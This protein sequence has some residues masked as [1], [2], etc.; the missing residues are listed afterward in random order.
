MYPCFKRSGMISSRNSA[1]EVF[2][3]LCIRVMQFYRPLHLM[4][5]KEKP[6]SYVYVPIAYMKQKK[7]SPVLC[8]FKVRISRT[9][10]VLTRFTIKA[11]KEGGTIFTPV[12]IFLPKVLTLLTNTTLLGFRKKHL[13]KTL[14]SSRFSFSQ[15]CS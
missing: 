2:C 11:K 10:A 6:R 7:K 8:F 14:G 13:L 9:S 3:V 4:S 12:I 15:R 1:R 5:I